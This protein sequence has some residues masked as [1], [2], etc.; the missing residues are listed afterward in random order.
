MGVAEGS[1]HGGLL[2]VI[3]GALRTR[4]GDG[5]ELIAMVT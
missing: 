3:A 5:G 2:V 1:G 4:P